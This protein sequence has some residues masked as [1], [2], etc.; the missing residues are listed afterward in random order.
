MMTLP[1][2]EI[3]R[4]IRDWYWDEKSRA[5][6]WELGVFLFGFMDYLESLGLKDATRSRHEANVWNIGIFTCQYG[7]HEKFEPEI[8][9]YPPFHDIEFRRKVSDSD[10]AIK[11]YESTCNKLA[12]YVAQ[13]KWLTIQTRSHEPSDELADYLVGLQLLERT[14]YQVGK[15]TPIDY[16]KEIKVLRKHFTTAMFKKNGWQDAILQGKQELEAVLKKVADLELSD[17][18]FRNRIKQLLLDNAPD[19]FNILDSIG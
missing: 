8:F 11:S 12:K 19:I 5:F 15:T 1:K 18:K 9:D 2:Y 14:F 16:S 10:S 3:E 6:A 17:D 13:K 4:Y 7:F